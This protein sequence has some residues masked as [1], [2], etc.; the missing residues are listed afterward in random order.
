MKIAVRLKE[1]LLML[2]QWLLKRKKLMIRKLEL[3]LNIKLIKLKTTFIIDN[4]LLDTTDQTGLKLILRLIRP[5]IL[6]EKLS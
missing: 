6:I 4:G 3:E 2:K 1:H 5:Q